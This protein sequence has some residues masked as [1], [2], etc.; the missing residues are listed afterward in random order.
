MTMHRARSAPRCARPNSRASST[1][2]AVSDGEVLAST[3]RR[4]AHGHHRC[5]WCRETIAARER[6]RDLRIADYGTVRTWREHLA[7]RDRI[8]RGYGP[9]ATPGPTTRT[10]T[11]TTSGG[12]SLSTRTATRTTGRAALPTPEASRETPPAP[13]VSYRPN[14]RASSTSSATSDERRTGAMRL[15]LPQPPPLLQHGHQRP[16]VPQTRPHDRARR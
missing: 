12:P 6:Y 2:S 8:T 13:R 7:C 16:M 4:A 3:I 1:S 9:T 11:R 5:G 15:H 14:S 10:A